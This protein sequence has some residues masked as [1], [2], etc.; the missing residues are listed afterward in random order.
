MPSLPFVLFELSVYVLALLCLRH[1]WRRG[2]HA[3]F[4]LLAGMAYGVLL[5]Y[6]TILTYEAYSYG[7]FL[8]MFRDAVPL[9]IGVSWG[10]IIYTAMETSERLGL[11]WP[12]RPVLDALLALNIDLSMDAIAIRLG[13]WTWGVEGRW[14][15]VPLANFYA[16]FVVVGSFSLLLRLGW[17]WLDPRRTKLLGTL[18]VPLL[19]VPLSVAALLRLL[20]AYAWLFYRNVP[21]P[22][23]V[24]AVLGSAVLVVL[25][26]ARRFQSHH[27]IDPVVLSVP[28]FFHTFFFSALFWADIY[29]QLPILV[30]ISTA[31][32]ISGLALHLWPSWSRV[33]DLKGFRTL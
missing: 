14:F 15:G 18:I 20:D 30:V 17:R 1:A 21:E 10:L 28:L 32:F 6:A 19:S 3:A 2:Q 22:L 12:L 24:S 16:W 7:R 11:P 23:I 27:P 25:P 9:C 31:M 26:F 5:E 13:F 8:I 4:G 29:R 33:V